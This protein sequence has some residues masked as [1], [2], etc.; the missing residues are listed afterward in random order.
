MGFFTSK[1]NLNS[2]VTSA[3][4]YENSKVKP[5]EIQ[6]LFDKIG[7]VY[8]DVENQL[9]VMTINIEIMKYALQ[10]SN[11]KDIV[12]N[13][14]ES[15]YTRFYNSLR[16]GSEQL[17]QY[18]SIIDNV[19]VKTSEILFNTHRQLASKSTLIFR[20]IIELED[21]PLPIIDRI[22]EQEFILTIDNWFNQARGVNDTYKIFDS[23][24]EKET[25]AP[26]D[27]DF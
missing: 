20:L 1:K 4:V 6:M 18:K 2:V 16:V 3:L 9:T 15:A 22:T 23:P 21:I 11:A 14:I 7:A 19:K 26:I 27:F 25:N 13:V 5:T 24:E 10:K 8:D 17:N 12:N